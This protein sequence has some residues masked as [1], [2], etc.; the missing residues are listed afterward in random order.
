[1][2]GTTFEM[3]MQ[4]KIT[5][6]DRQAEFDLFEVDTVESGVTGVTLAGDV[7]A[8]YEGALMRKSVGFPH[9]FD[10]VVGFGGGV[11]SSLV[12]ERD[13]GLA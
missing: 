8:R 1:M 2:L 12:A 10:V 13:L 5:T 9:V 4:I 6:E 11:G 3:H 7:R